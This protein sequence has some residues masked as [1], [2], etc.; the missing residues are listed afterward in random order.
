MRNGCVE[1]GLVTAQSYLVSSM[2][3]F[4]ELKLN[5]GTRATFTFTPLLQV[6][7][8]A[9]CAFTARCDVFDLTP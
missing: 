7:G 2:A 1:F 8:V 5:L 3:A 4:S 9:N 6:S